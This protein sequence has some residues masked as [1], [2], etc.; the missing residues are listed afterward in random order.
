VEKLGNAKTGTLVI[1][2]LRRVNAASSSGV[3]ISVVGLSKS[4]N[5]SLMSVKY[6][7]GTCQSK[8]NSYRLVSGLGIG[9]VK[10]SFT[11]VKSACTPLPVTIIHRGNSKMTFR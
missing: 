9:Y 6:S 7:I 3:Q 8:K 5:M 10:M 2:F 11:L 4:V 1:A